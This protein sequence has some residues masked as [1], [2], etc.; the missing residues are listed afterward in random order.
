MRRRLVGLACFIALGC[1]GENPPD[2]SSRHTVSALADDSGLPSCMPTTDAAAEATTEAEATTD[3]ADPRATVGEM[4]AVQPWPVVSIHVALTPSGKLLTFQGDFTVTGEQYM[5]DPGVPNTPQHLPN[6]VTDLFCAGQPVLADGRVLVLG[7]THNHDPGIKNVTAFDPVAEAWEPWPPMHY[8]RWYGTGITLGNGNVLAVSGTDEHGLISSI[9]EILNVQAKTWSDLTTAESQ[10]PIYPF[11]AQLADGRVLW[12]GASEVATPTKV[13]DLSTQLWTTIDGGVT[14]DGSSMTQFELGKFLKSG[15]ASDDGGSGNSLATAYVLDMNQPTPV[16]QPTSSMSFA[17]TF[18]NL[19]TLP[20]GTVLVTG[21]DRT[22]SASSDANGVLPSEIWNPATGQW[23]T[24]A[25]ITEAREYHSTAVLLPDGRVWISGGG[26]DPP[27]TTVDHQSYQIYS[28]PYLFKGPRPVTWSVPATGTYGSTMFV[29]TPNTDITRV[30]LIR[31]GSVTHAF[32][33]NARSLTLAFSATTGG[34]NVTMP[35]NGNAAPPG[36]YMLF[37]VNGNGVPSIG[38]FVRFAAPWEVVPDAGSDPT[39]EAGPEPGSEPVVEAGPDVND[40][41]VAS[42]ASDGGALE[43]SVDG[44]GDAGVAPGIDKTVSAHP[45]TTAA[46]FSAA[47]TTTGPNELLVAFLAS[48]GPSPGTQTF[49]SVAGGGLT[50]RMRARANAQ[51]GTSEIWQALAPAKLSSASITATRSNA[52]YVGSMLLVAFTG[53]SS[54]DG[55]TA[56]KSAATGQ[57]S[58][59]LTP[60]RSKSILWMVGNDWDGASARVASAG[61]T[62]IDE[63]LLPNI[64]DAFWVQ[65]ID[66]TSVAGS[67]ATL[68][69]T[70]P[71][72]DRWNLAAIEVP[73]AP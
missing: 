37:L 17:R 69:D 40:A 24:V 15:S 32:D 73:P 56:T 46:A 13:L 3:A 62:K 47:I 9:P 61:Q 53:A 71:T 55:V 57:P 35:A 22:K 51:A 2:P 4:G 19:T 44:G 41:G 52:G 50:W 29:G 67:A 66:A 42:D 70:S 34:Y 20:D 26:G 38:Q 48:D 21:G 18:E 36:Y 16:W 58:I 63:D 45:T 39:P 43:S 72:V 14:R 65:R 23:T 59:T 30:A 10:I 6:S 5:W 25:S 49:S 8:A 68:S 28:P 12:A 31:T 33:Q 1:G 64:G 54:S 27:T 11:V 7:G 60:G